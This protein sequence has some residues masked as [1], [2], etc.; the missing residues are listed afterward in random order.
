MNRLLIGAVSALLSQAS[1]SG[2]VRSTGNPILADGNYYS[3]DPAPLVVDGK[4]WIL[5]GRD[6]APPDVNDFIMREWQ[7]LSTAAPS[8]REWLHYPGV[9]RPEA[10]FEWAEPGR[11]YASQIVAGPDGKLYLY[12]PVLEARSDARD[13]F[14]IGVAVA[15]NP[16]G[17]W[18]D[19]H[20]SGPIISQRLPVAN[21]IQNIDPTVLVDTDGRVYIYWGTFG[22][23]RGMELERDMITPKG[24]IVSVTS[25]PGFFEAP[26]IMKRRGVYYLLYAGNNTGPNS[27]CTPTLY[28]A[29]IA[30]GTA[31]SPLGPWTYRGIVLKPVSSTT[32]HPGAVEF[33]GRW[34]LTYHTA[35]AKDGGHFRRS[36][37]IDELAW[38]DSVQ[39]PAIKTVAPTRAPQPAAAPSRNVATWA[40]AAASNDPIPHQYWIKAINDGRVRKNPL[41][42]ELWG[43]WT[44][45]DRE[46]HAWLE[47]RWSEPV[48]INA[49][50]V[51]FWADR[52]PGSG[53]GVAPPK[54]WR[55]EYWRDGWRNVP[56]AD[57]YGVATDQPQE[58]NFDTITTC[59][60]R[61]VI[62][63]SSN[64]GAHAALA[65]QEWEV[66]TAK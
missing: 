20:P 22:K 50:R 52:P 18:R 37:A 4:L 57:R 63:A 2:P 58:T 30:Y 17:P 27:P 61:M 28:H 5:A 34:Y 62:E 23:L 45:Q 14:A 26:W 46:S 66:L 41:P 9:T 55:L 11:A 49:A 21:D 40:T 8:S 7:L 10:I 33:N 35:D 36:V 6:E 53:S 59:C 12:A 38:D 16:L 65:V 29:C 54:S 56:G 47:Y 51:W 24:P 15:D 48:T 31:A 13:R 39:P 42:P 43:N 60:L 25:L 1:Y 32:S 64:D 44:Q 19:A 3:A